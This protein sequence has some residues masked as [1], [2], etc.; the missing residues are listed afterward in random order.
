MAKWMEDFEEGDMG[1]KPFSVKEKNWQGEEPMLQKKSAELREESYMPSFLLQENV[2]NPM[3]MLQRNLGNCLQIID[4]EVM[5]GYVTKLEQLPVVKYQ[6]NEAEWPDV[7][8]FKITELVY[9]DD[10]FSVHKLSAVFHSL[11]SRPC[12]II[13]MLK[14]DGGQCDFYLGVRSLNPFFSTGRMRDMLE[15]SLKGMFPGSRIEPYVD[16]DM[17]ADMRSILENRNG[18]SD[19]VSSVTCVADYK[20]EQE[21]MTNK[22]FI[23]GL[24]KFVESMR[25][26]EYTAL[27]LA[28]SVSYDSLCG[29]RSEYENIYT[30]ISPFADMQLSFSANTGKS[31]S[32]G[33]SQGQTSS[34]SFGKSLG[35][36]TSGSKTRTV[37]KS[38]SYGF[39]DTRGTTDSTSDGTTDTHGHTRGVNDSV[40]DAHSEGKFQSVSGSVGGSFSFGPA[41]AGPGVNA[42]VSKSSGSSSSDTHSVSHG[43]SSSDSISNSISKTL[44]HGINQ[45]HSDTNTFANSSSDSETAGSSR[46]NTWSYNAGEA[47]NFVDTETLTESFGSSQGITMHAQ[48]MMLSSTLKRLEMQLERLEECEGVGMWRFASYFIGESPAE[49]ETAANTYKSIM[50]GTQTGLERSAVNTWSEGHAYAVKEYLTDFLHPVFEYCGFSYDQGRT[51]LVNPASLVSTNELAIHMGLPRHSVKGLPVVEHAV[52]GQEILTK[53]GK[54]DH[55]IAI[56]DIYHLGEKTNARVTLDV[57]SLAM[58]TF[59]TGSTGSGKSNTIYHILSKLQKKGIPF[60]VVEP[61]KGEYKHVFQDINCFGTNPIVGK[62]IQINPFAFPEEIHVL[63][64]VDRLIEIFNVCWPMYAAMPAVL[65]DSIERAYQSAGWDLD[66]SRNTKV[67]GLFPT[68]DDVLR[69]LN[70]TI[71]ASAYS[72]DT[73]G[74]YIGS[75]STRIK[76]LTNGINGKIFVGQEMSLQELFDESAILDISRV[77]SMETKSLIMGLVILKLQEYRISNAEDMNVPLKHVTV[78]EEAHNILKRTSS[79]QSA[80]SANLQGKSVEMLSNAIA[81]IRTFGEGIMIVDQAPDLLDTSAI[82]N[83]NTKIVLRLPESRDREQ[84]GKSMALSDKQIVELSKLP[85]GVAAVYQNDWQEAVLCKIDEYIPN[86]LQKRKDKTAHQHLL[87][88]DFYH[89]LL[90]ELLNP[91]KINAEETAKKIMKSNVSAKIKL[92]LIQNLQRPNLSYEWAVADFIKKNYDYSAVFKGTQSGDWKTLDEL[93]SIME[94]NIEGQFS[95]FTHEELR[96]VLYYMCRIQHELFPDNPLIEKVRTECLK[97]ECV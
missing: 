24:E 66:L 30:Q 78:L 45:S 89:E 16:D 75:L 41:G 95:N 90:R 17:Q 82:R 93:A 7:Q 33:T 61:A 8:L 56:G 70:H 3:A 5:K 72:A 46:Q 58:H 92:D 57:N 34:Q 60:L 86:R 87:S 73:K 2:Q 91:R 68:F 10:E 38:E 65:K 51:L 43:T 18:V 69:E 32:L 35:E 40:S 15:S 13:L 19:S 52:F 96:R 53:K 77:G 25:G 84:T 23:Q 59:V 4:E 49:T 74:D 54:S 88:R 14:S 85:T 71:N 9:Q 20:Q 27:L 47:F 44:S 6:R 97:G 62:M 64:H 80:D 28:D 39:A 76:S 63:E 67:A 31:S 94:Q 29:I 21:G 42:S 37:G 12:T 1:K 36:G 48:N 26:K 81:E 83:T 11:S 22:E 55:S 79:E 50:S